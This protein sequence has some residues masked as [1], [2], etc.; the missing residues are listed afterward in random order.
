MAISISAPIIEEEEIQAVTRVLRSGMLAA[1]RKTQELER[2][3]A[4]F[5]ETKYAVAVSSGTAALHASVH[6]LG[7]SHGDEVITSPFSFAASANAI[8]MEGANVVFADI[9][10]D[11]FCIDPQKIE[12]KITNKTKAILPV[13]LFG[14]LVD[15]ECIRNI[16]RGHTLRTI[17]DACQSVG[18]ERNGIKAG[19]VG[20]VGCFSF[21][22]T[23]NVISG[24][25]GM[26]TTNDADIAERCRRFRHHG[27][28]EH[29]R[30]E[31]WELGYNYRTTDI[32]AAIA[33]EQL[34]K[35]ER[36]TT[37]RIENAKHLTEGLRDIPGIIL[38]TIHQNS[39]HVFHQYTIRVTEECKRTRD[40][41]VNH[42]RAHNIGVGIY[43]PKPLHLHPHFA[44]QGYEKGDF[45]V[46]EKL[47][48][49]VL[50]LPVHPSLTDQDIEVVL[51]TTREYAQ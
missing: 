46:A 7:I 19:S 35:I 39:T 14:Q 47:A 1:G 4:D 23:K 3:F 49:E 40:E 34:K 28:S 15:T 27:Q 41:L 33:L 30:Y 10:E 9:R 17:E 8:L 43:Y 37:A 2:L 51:N 18:A 22:A 42:L 21:Y 48:T 44:R 32:C 25:G 50:S 5:C 20:D 6:A 12:A 36:F 38:P 16:A 26:I 29:T 31:Y 13:D 45:P 24:E 11:D